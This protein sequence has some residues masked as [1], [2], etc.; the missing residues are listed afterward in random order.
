MPRI[1][2]CSLARLPETVSATGA[3]HI[4]TLINEQTLVVRP[5]SVAADNHL[6]L[7]FNDIIEPAD[8]MVPPAVAHV[9]SLIAFVRDWDR[10]SPLVIHCFAGVSRSTAAAF[11]A[12]CA[13][14]PSL[15]EAELAREIRLRSPTATPNIR[16]VRFA[17]EILKR[18]GRMVAAIEAIGRGRDTYEGVPFHFAVG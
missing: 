7:G 15:D 1:H 17:D 11:I 10:E 2:V 4:L 12:L 6:F 3:S 5:E 16:M 9:E 13:L 14:D 18:D 8:G